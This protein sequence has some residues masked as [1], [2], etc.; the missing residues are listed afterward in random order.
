MESHVFGTDN[1][2]SS[3]VSHCVAILCHNLNMLLYVTKAKHR[4]YTTQFDRILFDFIKLRFQTYV[5]EQTTAWK[6]MSLHMCSYCVLHGVID[7]V[8][9]GNLS[10]FIM[11]WLYHK[12]FINP[13]Y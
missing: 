11:L 3:A 12:C 4:N 6:L 1:A 9:F 13:N 7:V 2:N 5:T 10:Y 8:D